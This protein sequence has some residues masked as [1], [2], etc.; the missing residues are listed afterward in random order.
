MAKTAFLFPGQGAQFVGMGKDLFESSTVSRE[1]F[2]RANEILEFP[3]TERM[4][5]SGTADEAAQETEA[6][7][8]RQTEI[9]QPAL[10]L[11]S[12]VCTALLAERGIRPDATAGHSVGEYGALVAAG[13]MTFEDGLQIIKIRGELMGAAG[14]KRPGTMSAIIGLDD[15]LIERICI[16]CTSDGE[17]VQ[18]ANFNAPGQIVISGDIAAVDRAVAMAMESGARKTIVLQ[19]S[20]AFHSP[21]VEEASAGLEEK[22]KKLRLVEPECPVYLNV[23]GR[24]SR[25]PEEIRE[26]LIQQVT[27][28]V[29]WAQS[30]V[31]MRA[32]GVE[33]Y[34]EVGAGRVL[35]GL[36]KRTLDRRT[37]ARQAGTLEDFESILLNI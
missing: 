36:V 15:A 18:A 2:G 7:A 4:F 21:L 27:A 19:V 29:K 12:C 6:S 34:I 33:S 5:G 31:A 3:I 20:G 26:R 10:F 23:T 16:D 9:G 13:A 28:P 8:L 22:L 24:A 35:S 30:L 14:Y 25:D 17:V 11:H 37:P 1:Y 32:D